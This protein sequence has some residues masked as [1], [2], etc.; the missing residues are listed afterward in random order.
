MIGNANRHVIGRIKRRL[1]FCNF[2]LA[3]KSVIDEQAGE[4]AANGSVNQ[5]SRHGG[6]DTATECTDDFALAH[7]VSYLCDG[8]INEGT[9]GPSWLAMT[10][11]TR[12]VLEY[13]QAMLCVNDFWVKLNA[14]E[15]L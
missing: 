10:N 11:V 15:L 5:N 14:E 6:I 9:H 3:H 13:S 8:L 1:Q 4:L 7:L 2:I 12:K